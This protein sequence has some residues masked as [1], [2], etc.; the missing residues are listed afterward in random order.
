MGYSV[1]ITLFFDKYFI[2]KIIFYYKNN[3]LLIQK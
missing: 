3:I 1:M 2:T